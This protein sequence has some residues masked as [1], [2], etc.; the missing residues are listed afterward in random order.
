M[1]LNLDYIRKRLGW[2]PDA[3]SSRHLK[4]MLGGSNPGSQNLLRESDGIRPHGGGNPGDPGRRRYEHTQVG[5]TIIASVLLVMIVIIATQFVL[6]GYLVLGS[7]PIAPGEG[8][9]FVIGGILVPL[10]VLL[11]LVFAVLCFGTL[12]IGVY[13]DAVRIRFGP[14]GL[15]KREFPLSEIATAAAVTNPWYYGYGLRWTPR[16]PLYNVAGKY[17]VEIGLYSGKN[18]RIGTDEPDLILQAIEQAK[19]GR[20]YTPG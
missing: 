18:V 19:K 20:R 13:D 8:I 16:G 7:Q 5:R 2:C 10:A 6:G 14:I 17:A 15:F 3:G 9:A 11:I 12:T 4:R 1:T